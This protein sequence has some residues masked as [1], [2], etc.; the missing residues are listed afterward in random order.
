[1]TFLAVKLVAFLMLVAGVALF[2]DALRVRHVPLTDKELNS[3][4]FSD[5]S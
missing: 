3:R 4:C 1:M 2:V 5:E